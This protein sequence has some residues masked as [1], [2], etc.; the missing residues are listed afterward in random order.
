MAAVDAIRPLA[1]D[2]HGDRR[3]LDPDALR[4]VLAP[5]F[6]RHVVVAAAW[7]FGSVARGRARPDSD[8]DIG[9]VF[10]DRHGSRRDREPTLA[11]LA[12][13][14]AAISG[15]EEVDAVDL[16]AQGPIFCLEV[17]RHGTALHEADRARR[18]DFVSDTIVGAHD[19]RPTYELATRGKV[20][21]LR[22]W[23]REHYDL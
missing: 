10:R 2:G 12:C 15:F 7:V 14:I 9:V 3:V 22:R 8:L 17:L 21:A 20:A 11:E 4:R 19:F 5:V 1:P 6:D 16:E 13:E 23:L 18:V